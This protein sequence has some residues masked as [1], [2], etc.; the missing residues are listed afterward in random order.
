MDRGSKGHPL[1]TIP[2][3]PWESKASLTSLVP[4]IPFFVNLVVF[5]LGALLPSLCPACIRP[6]PLALWP[7]G[8][9]PL[10]TQGVAQRLL[11]PSAG[12]A[13]GPLGQNPAVAHRK[14]PL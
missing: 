6:G 8:V 13:G 2:L 12:P 11:L 7:F 1:T 14:A 9:G 4:Y 5:S 10:H 3:L